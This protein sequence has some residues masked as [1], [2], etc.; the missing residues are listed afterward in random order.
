[1]RIKNLGLI[2]DKPYLPYYTDLDSNSDIKYADD[3]NILMELPENAEYT[4]EYC[5]QPDIV[6]DD[7][8]YKKYVYEN[9]LY[10]PDENREPIEKLCAEKGFKADDP[11][12]TQ[13]LADYFA[14]DFKYTLSPGLVPWKTDFVNYF[15]FEHKE[16]VC[17][18]FAS[19]GTLIYRTLGIPARYAEGYAL[20]YVMARQDQTME[21]SENP[22][23]WYSGADALTPVPVTVQVKDHSAHAWVEIYK[24]G[25]G[26]V[27]AELTPI[28]YE[29]L[30]KMEEKD[31]DPDVSDQVM[32]LFLS[33][34]EEKKEQS[35][36]ILDDWRQKAAEVMGYLTAAL[37]GAFLLLLAYAAA[38]VAYRHIKRLKK[39]APKN[40]DSVIAL[41]SYIIDILTYLGKL[42]NTSHN[43]V[44]AALSPYIRT[45]DV[46]TDTVQ[47]ILYAPDMPEKTECENVFI[48]LHNALEKILKECKLGDKLK[49]LI[50][51]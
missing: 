2:S 48:S 22:T 10:V 50:K 3:N 18:H 46:I 1:M 49:I 8:E 11:E 14:Q 29:E 44:G 12:L 25:Y 16:G 39:F 27:P 9:F 40:E 13:K 37:F 23:D 7:A 34:T 4:V 21:T 17:A 24:D 36:E 43:A 30:E 41:Y 51:L 20:D 31:N 47:Q 28:N 42:E 5:R 19:A 15:L 26:W 6:T 32:T 38:L 35:A 45:P 33:S